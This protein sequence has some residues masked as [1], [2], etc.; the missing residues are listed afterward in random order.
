MLAQPMICVADVEAS[1][2]WFQRTLG[3]LSA[4]GG[5]EYDMLTF[6]GT[7]VLQLH[8]WDAHE[9]P[10]LGKPGVEPVGN[11]VALWF[12]CTDA[13]DSYN[14]AVRANAQILEP[15]HVNPLARHLE[16]WLREPNGY[17]VVVSGPY[18]ELGSLAESVP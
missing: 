9:H 3:L 17:V 12:A 4:H 6:D 7:V 10:Y 15:L 16:F 2:A 14:R 13:E 5:S 8:A 18:G 11:G 1:S